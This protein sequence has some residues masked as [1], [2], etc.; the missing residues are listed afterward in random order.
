MRW[1]SLK[2]KSVI[3]LKIKLNLSFYKRLEKI[4][5]EVHY[6][7]TIRDVMRTF[8]RYKGVKHYAIKVIKKYHD[9]AL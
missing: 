2:R 3:K 6:N 4:Y 5:D 1:T 7:S 9:S 8:L